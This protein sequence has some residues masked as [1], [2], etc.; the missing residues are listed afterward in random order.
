MPEFAERDEFER[1]LTREFADVGA[2]AL[3]RLLR[4]IGDPPSLANVPPSYWI[5]IQRELARRYNPLLKEI[6]LLGAGD[7]IQ[8]IGGPAITGGIIRIAAAGGI[9]IEWAS[10][11]QAAVDWAKSYTYDLVKGIDSYSRRLL[12][13]QVS[14]FFEESLS[15]DELR[16]VLA[17][18]FGTTR[19]EAI[20]QTEVTRASVQGELGGL[21]EIEDA[22]IEMVTVFWT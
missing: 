22:G 14:R 2:Q 3:D 8:E 13:K 10:I 19:G 1:K 20:G 15:F 9:A 12:Q 7:V 18:T 4:L 6:Y 17:P 21:Q 16:D 11:N 5:A